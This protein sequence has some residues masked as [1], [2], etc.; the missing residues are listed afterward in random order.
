MKNLKPKKLQV[1]ISEIPDHMRLK[2]A[3]QILGELIYIDLRY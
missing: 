1:T 3:T 2:K